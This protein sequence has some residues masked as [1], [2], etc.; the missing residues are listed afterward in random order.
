[1]SAV[2]LGVMNLG[3]WANTDAHDQRRIIDRAIDAG[4]N[5]IDTADVYS[6]GESERILGEVL[7]GRTDRD[8]L[9]IATKFHSPM[10]EGLNNRGN[11]RHWIARAVEGSL[12]RLGVDHID[13]YQIHRPDPTVDIDDTLGA[14]TDLVRAGKIRYFGTSTFT[15]HQ[16]TEARFTATLRQREYPVSEQL[17]YSILARAVE[18]EVLPVADKYQLGVLAWSPLAGGWLAGGG[19]SASTRLGRQPE[20][21]SLDIEANQKKA[22]IVARLESI[23]TDAGLTLPRLAIAFV[24]ANAVIS[25]VLVGPRTPEQLEDALTAADLDLDL[26]VLDSI[27]AVAAPGITVNQADTGFPLS[28]VGELVRAQ[29]RQAQGRTAQRRRD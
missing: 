22:E 10:G 23:A 17:P 21:H 24:L 20:R 9:L 5:L 14:L 11:S 28:H 8:D 18:R 6:Q 26:A 4:I 7:R 25:T 19:H 3:A 29:R 1:M 2:S 27:D 16:L 12:T 13:L 15:G